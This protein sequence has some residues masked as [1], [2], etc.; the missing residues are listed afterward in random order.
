MTKKYPLL[1][2]ILLLVVLV[3][4]FGFSHLL[5]LE[6]F[7]DAITILLAFIGVLKGQKSST[8]FGFASGLIIGLLS[9]NF[10]INMLSRA[11]GGYLAGFFHSP[12]DSHA[13]EKQK[14]K[15]F[16]GAVITSVFFTNAVM[17]SVY[18]PLGNPVAYRIIT[19]G[20]LQALMTSILA[21]IVRQLF[22]RK[23]FAD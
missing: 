17:V 18:N 12:E 10:G 11:T 13:T 6:V 5:L 22:L 19:L 3:Q 1:L 16:Y 20:L 2:F 21:F 4:E 14:N 9:G 15:R 23:S 8:S 7:P